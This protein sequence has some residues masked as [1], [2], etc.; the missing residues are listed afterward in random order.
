M[1][2]ALLKNALQNKSVTTKKVTRT[3]TTFNIG[4]IKLKVDKPEVFVKKHVDATITH[5]EKSVTISVTNEMSEQQ[6][7]TVFF[8]EGKF[9][10]HT[11]NITTSTELAY[12]NEVQNIII[13]LMKVRNKV[14][15][16]NEQIEQGTHVYDFICETNV[17]KIKIA[18]SIRTLRNIFI[19]PVKVVKTDEEIAHAKLVR[20]QK[21]KVEKSNKS[22]LDLIKENRRKQK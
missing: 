5:G 7:I 15:L 8:N 22:R 14:V 20:E 10:R 13:E 17:E 1:S 6:N 4:N 12:A 3:S 2:A 11:R 19:P 16:T 21:Q 9:E 18:T